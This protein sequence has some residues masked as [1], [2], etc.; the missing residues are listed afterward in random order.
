MDGSVTT[1]VLPSISFLR[2]EQTVAYTGLTQA[3]EMNDGNKYCAAYVYMF[4]NVRAHSFG[5]HLS[6]L[7]S[8]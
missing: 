2:N 8:V 7:D 3:A 6:D 1:H 5:L 4:A